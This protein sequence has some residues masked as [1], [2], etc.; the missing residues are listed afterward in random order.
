[1]SNGLRKSAQ[2]VQELLDEF[3]VK[4]E[5]VE[6]SEST[7]TSQEAADAIG[8]EVGQIA[9]SLIFKT[10]TT[11]RPVLIV[12]S[13]V[14]RVNEKKMANFIGEKLERANAEFVLATAGF[15][16]GG[17][18]PIKRDNYAAV[19]MDEDL[20]KYEEV[21]AAAGT[22]H[23]VFKVSPAVLRDIAAATVLAVK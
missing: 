11:G 7:R 22:P 17:I 10:K 6:M 23:A 8:C 18:P 20:L 14:N 2:K 3:G 16:I 13:G 15:A 19:Y 9:K 1:M 5:V 21:W 12:A 4:L